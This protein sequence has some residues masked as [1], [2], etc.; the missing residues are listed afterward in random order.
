MWLGVC[1]V[2]SL[3]RRLTGDCLRACCVPRLTAACDPATSPVSL[4]DGNGTIAMGGI[5]MFTAPASC[6]WLIKGAASQ[7]VHLWFDSVHF[8]TC[9]PDG[10][11]VYSGT[12][13]DG[14][15]VL[16]ACGPH[17]AFRMSVLPARAPH[18]A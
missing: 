10:V 2:L 16:T 14:A 18:F 9:H 8:S 15:E 6:S 13:Q 17:F 1:A 7:T 12:T 5:D 11:H 4:S 3:A